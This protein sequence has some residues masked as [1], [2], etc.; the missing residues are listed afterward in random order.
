MTQSA[1]S[2]KDWDREKLRNRKEKVKYTKLI[3]FLARLAI[4]IE[5]V[6]PFMH[7]TIIGLKLYQLQLQSDW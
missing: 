2:H 3:V 4:M 5:D 6:V 7:T 1:E